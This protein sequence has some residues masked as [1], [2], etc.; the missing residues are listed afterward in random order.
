VQGL[1][2]KVTLAAPATILRRYQIFGQIFGPNLSPDLWPNLP[3]A[4]VKSSTKF[5]AK[6]VIFFLFRWAKNLAKS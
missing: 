4:K 6:S 5:F 2:S 1:R 3:R